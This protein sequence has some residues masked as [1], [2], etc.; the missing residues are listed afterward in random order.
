MQIIDVFLDEWFSPPLN[1]ISSRV[2]LVKAFLCPI[3]KLL[4]FY[5]N[6]IYRVI[7]TQYGTE[8]S[9]KKLSG[10]L[11]QDNDIQVFKLC[12]IDVEEGSMTL[13]ILETSIQEAQ[14]N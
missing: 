11:I 8:N 10:I 14:Q 12:S 6:Y 5:A 7:R 13:S 4:P 2:R 1:L 9:L 3:S